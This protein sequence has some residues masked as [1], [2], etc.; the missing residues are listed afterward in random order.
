MNTSL[1][2]IGAGP[3]DPELI[4]VKG[5]KALQAADVVLYDSLVSNQIFDLAYPESRPELIFVGKRKGL[6][7]N[8]QDEINNMILDHLQAGK[9]VVRL[10]GGD[11]FIFARGVEEIEF[12]NQHGFAVKIIPGLTSGLSV[13][14]TLGVTLTLREQSDAVSLATAHNFDQAK[15]KHWLEIL[16]R[17]ST[18]V[19]YMGLFK[20]VE[21]VEALSEE[22]AEDFPAIAIQDGTL[23]NQ[24]IIS[25]D[26]ANLPQ[27]I[28]DQ[29]LKSPVLL[30]F[31]EHIKRELNLLEAGQISQKLDTISC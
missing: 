23:E 16:K 5:L 30:V 2:L 24:K 20:V 14:V 4:T 1:T 21:I 3:G 29:S 6:S 22:L 28:I 12:V 8:S 17:G 31:G 18:L 11:P 10:K 19:V 27:A 15:A 13:P 9:N 25:S 7:L 26:L